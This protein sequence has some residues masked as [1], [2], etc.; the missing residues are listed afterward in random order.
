MARAHGIRGEVA[1]HPLS[2][3][4]ERFAPGSVLYAGDRRFV[5]TASRPHQNRWVV[6]LEGID[7][8]TA[9]EALRG[10]VFTADPLP[11]LPEDEF[12]LHDVVGA[13]VVDLAGAVHGRVVAIEPNPAHDLLVL[14]SGGL[15]PVVFVVERTGER[16]VVDVPEGLLDA[17]FVAANRPAVERRKPARKRRPAT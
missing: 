5:V 15:V 6:Q 4:P 10:Q 3:R 7:D 11:S 2:N 8:R 9:A 13:E 16:V 12:W 14:D 17:E 1:I